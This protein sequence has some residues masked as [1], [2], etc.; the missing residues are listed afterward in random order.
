MASAELFTLHPRLAADTLPVRELALSSLR[1]MNDATYPWVLLVPR[2][3]DARE[4]HQLNAHHQSTLWQEL[5]LV[6]RA[7]ERLCAPH[8]LNVGALGN[9]VPQLHVHVVARFE[10]DAAWPG[11]VWGAVAP[12]AY[13]DAASTTF[14]ARLTAMLDAV[15]D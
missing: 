2:V 1:L 10:G 8:K 4:L 6:S 11:P 9:L 12:T 15:S 5:M 14:V 3:P 7:L 13:D